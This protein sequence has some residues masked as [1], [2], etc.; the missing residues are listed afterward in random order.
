[1]VGIA[2]GNEYICTAEEMKDVAGN[3]NN[4]EL[5]HKVLDTIVGGL[6]FYVDNTNDD[7]NMKTDNNVKI[8]QPWPYI[9]T[10]KDSNDSVFDINV[11]ACAGSA[12]RCFLFVSDMLEKNSGRSKY[13]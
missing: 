4:S 12:G 3:V 2:S 5:I 11:V 9:F 8:D 1:M 7:C 13:L 6:G 10:D